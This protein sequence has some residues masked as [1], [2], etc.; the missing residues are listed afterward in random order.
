MGR[1]ILL[2][3][4]FGFDNVGDEAILEAECAQLRRLDPNVEL[5]ALIDN[6]ARA[7][8]L[9]LKAYKRKSPW[10]IYKAISACD[11]VISGGGG[12]FQDSTGVSSVMYYGAILAM[13]AILN[14]PSFIFSQGFGPIRTDLGKM[15]AK[16][17][18][19]LA[20]RASFRDEESLQEFKKY[21]PKV[22]AILTAD[23]AFL[24]FSKNKELSASML[25]KCG[26]DNVKAPIAVVSLRSWFGLEL[27][28][29]AEAFNKWLAD[30]AEED[31]P[32]LLVL[33]M[34][35][36]YDEGISRRF[37]SLIKYPCT[38]APQ[39]K[40]TE[41]AALLASE[42]IEMAAAMRLH[43]VI[44][45]AAASK[46]TL[47]IAY[48]PKVS[49]ICQ[50]CGAPCLPLEK[51]EADELIRKLHETWQRRFELGG[52]IGIN[53]ENMRDKALQAFNIALEMV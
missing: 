29:K 35:Y 19:P 23:P 15:L 21:A 10:H 5:S 26:L 25:Q 28:S 17:L 11:L 2:S 32:H 41:I 4:Y 36:W 18:L 30:F 34:Q 27:A 37:V 40:A 50:L 51:L 38:L 24:L 7:E 45:A 22:E 39:L 52:T 48:D 3:G 14:K 31:R 9:Q 13:A 53:A 47:G 33:P 20:C 43:T 8:E 49:R 1:K 46:A 12:L 42:Q 6:K 16:Q 44:L